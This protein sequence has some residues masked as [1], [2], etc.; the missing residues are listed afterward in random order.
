M[1]IERS[2]RDGLVVFAVSG[3]IGVDNITEL[4][5]VIDSEP[6]Q[7]KTLNL[8]DVSLVDRHA[9]RFLARCVAEGTTLE[10][11]PIYLREWIVR[12]RT[13]M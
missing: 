11:C 13:S 5:K 7:R 10:R 8:K 2:V 9:V 1:R 12:E 4:R 6:G 3:R